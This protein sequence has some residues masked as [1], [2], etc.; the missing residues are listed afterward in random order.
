MSLAPGV[1]GPARLL[2]MRMHRLLEFEQAFD[3]YLCGK[4]GAE[5]VRLRAKK[6]LAIGLPDF[7][8]PEKRSD[9]G[10]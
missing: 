4:C 6:M 3:D 7:A 8:L 5:E 9:H 10:N 1:R 2:L